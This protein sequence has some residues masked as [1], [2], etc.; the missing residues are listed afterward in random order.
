MKLQNVVA[1]LALVIGASC[2]SN[3]P[4]PAAQPMAPG[5]PVAPVAAD[6]GQP[7]MHATLEALG[8]A[9][10]ELTAASPNKGGHR[11]KAL[12]LVQHATSEVHEGIA[13]ANAHAHEAGAAEPPA[14][15][16]PVNGEV[17]GAQRQPH[18]ANAMVALR[19]ARKQLVEAKGDKGGH[20]AKAL[21]MIDDALRQVHDGIMFADHH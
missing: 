19:E 13:Y 16:E 11:A 12:E 4:P 14:P 10:A 17:A 5:A 20:R 2:A 7:K 15:P 8:K 3:P 21:A 6:N 1:S 18:M 9:N